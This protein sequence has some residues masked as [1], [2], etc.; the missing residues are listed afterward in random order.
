MGKEIRDKCGVLAIYSEK[1]DSAEV[2][3]DI[4]NGLIALQHRGQESGGISVI[5]E[6]KI[7]TKKGM[8]LVTDIFTTED[9]EKLTGRAGIGHV[10]Y[11]TT[12]SSTI[13]NAQPLLY[14]DKELEI[15]ISFNGNIVN[16]EELKQHFENLH[17]MP[18]SCSADTELILKMFAAE[19]RKEMKDGKEKPHNVSEL[20]L[21]NEKPEFKPYFKAMYSIM[22][23]LEGAYSLALLL[24]DGTLIAARDPKGFKPFSIGRK[25]TLLS[26]TI[27]IASETAGLDALDAQFDRDIRPGEIVVIRNNEV[28]TQVL[29]HERH[30]HCMFEWVYFSRT[31]SIIEDRPVYDVRVRL[32]E[33]LAKAF[34]HEIDVVIPIPDSGR[35]AARGFARMAA[36]PME[37][38]LIKNRYI[39]RT[40][41]MPANDRRKALLKLKLNPVRSVIEGKRIAVVDDSIIR[42]NTMKRLVKM[43]RDNGAKEVHLLVSCPPVISPCYMGIDFPTYKELIA[44]SRTITQIAE[45]LGAD[46]VTY[47]DVDALARALALSD[48]DSCMACLTGVYPTPKIH[49]YAQQMKNRGERKPYTIAVLASG[50]GTNLQSVIDNVENKK[51]DARVALVVSDK[52]GAQALKRAEK[53]GIESLHI[54]PKKFP[55]KEEYEKEMLK[56]LK[57]KQVDLIVLAG[58]TRIVGKTLL[59]RY[60]DR[61]INIH[62]TLLPKFKGC[63]GLECHKKVIEAGELETG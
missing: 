62:P 50:R 32:G 10:R 12:G 22:K 61:I 57:E 28:R 56:H 24:N 35:S 15:A 23:Q 38:G 48:G 16:Y 8:G 39:H 7:A 51:L 36:V 9:I 33:E 59:D 25:K 49:D 6:G 3:Y 14:R 63:M 42:G 58:Y 54:D 55:S 11:S 43:L 45:D 1:G 4:Y 53:H 26:D 5:S 40:F 20:L 60:R 47:N 27:F 18:F 52:Q 44:S 31:D 21:Q 34:K 46:S 37:E 17:Q 30:S 13:E 2:P 41:I 29:F 19:L